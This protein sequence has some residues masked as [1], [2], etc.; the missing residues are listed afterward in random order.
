MTRLIVCVSCAGRG[1][2]NP[3]W[4]N[5]FVIPATGCCIGAAGVNAAAVVAAAAAGCMGACC[6][7]WVKS[8]AAGP[9]ALVAGEKKALWV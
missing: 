3:I 5:W 7:C 4:A 9:A 6:C 1:P 2:L 8:G